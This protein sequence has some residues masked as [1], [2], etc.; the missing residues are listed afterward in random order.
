MFKASLSY[1]SPKTKS[2]FRKLEQRPVKLY[3][4]IAYL[5]QNI[6]E[7]DDGENL[8]KGL[9]KINSFGDKLLNLNSK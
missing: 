3:P 8:F 7:N 9:F 1:L 5:K 2:K 4:S 6:A